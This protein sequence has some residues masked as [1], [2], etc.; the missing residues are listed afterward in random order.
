MKSVSESDNK[1]MQTYKDAQG[2]INNLNNNRALD[3]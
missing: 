1:Y 3:R 2:N